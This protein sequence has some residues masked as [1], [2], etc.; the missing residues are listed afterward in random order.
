VGAD[1]DAPPI[2]A[3]RAT[4]LSEITPAAKAAEDGDWDDYP[5]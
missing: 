3:E 4:A 2:T 5:F 1:Y